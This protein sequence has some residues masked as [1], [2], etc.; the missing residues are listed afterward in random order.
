MANLSPDER[1]II[2]T[3]PLANSL[4]YLREPLRQAEQNYRP[5]SISYNGTLTD[6]DLTRQE[7]ISNLLLALMG[8]KVAFNL[9]SRTES[10]DIASELSTLFRRVRN[11]NMNYEHYRAL[12]RLVVKKAPDVNIWNAVFDLIITVSRT[13][14]PTSIPPSFN[15][16]PVTKSSSS[17][18]GSEQ[19]R[20][21]IESAM[22]YEIKGC[23]YRNV[24]GFFEKYFEGRPWSR[25]SKGIY[26]AVKKQYRGGRW[27][28]FPDPPDEDAVWKWLSRFQDKH[29]SDSRGILYT[30][31]STSDLTGGEAQRQLDVFIKRRGMETG[32]KHDWKDV[33]VIGELKRSEWNLKK[34]LLQLAR[35]MRDAFT[36]QPTR[37]FIHGFFLHGTIMELWV[38]D[39]SGPYSSGEFDIHEE[40]EKFIRAI[41]GY[42][43][44][45]DEELGL[46][47]FTEQDDRGRLIT[48]SKD[49]TGKENRMQLYEAPFVKQRAVVCRG[50]TCFR[51]SD[52]ANVVKFSWT[53]DK[54]PPEA[55]HL[56]LAREKGVEGIAKLI[57]YQRVTS[58]NELRCGLTFPSPHR[59][60]DVTASA[61]TSFSQ[62]QLGQS[63]GP[64]QNPSISK[65][66]SKRKRP[67]D[68]RGSQKRSR[69]D[70]QKSKLSQQYEAAQKPGEPAVSLY[71]SDNG[72]YSNR[73][74]G[75]LA[76][77]PAGRALSEF[78]QRPQSTNS[79]PSLIRELLT[80]L[81]DAIKAHRSLLLKANILH[82]DISENNIIITNKDETGFSGMLIDLDLAKVLGNG[83]SGA[84]H[85]T[86]TMEFM[87]IEVLLGIDHTYRHDL[88]SF[89]Y[90]LIWLCARR[91]WDL[92]GNPKG[93]PKESV[94]TK[95]YSGS[96]KDMARSKLGDMHVDGFEDIL[97]EF[98]TVFDYVKPLCRKIRGILFPLQ[99]DGT[100]FKGTRPDLPERLYD[101]IIEAFDSVI[102]DIPS[103]QES[104]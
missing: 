96:L 81:R 27:T 65:T 68:E 100:L 63:F 73:I 66:S 104:E 7:A 78:T 16:T 3:H 64:I 35:Y 77:A 1:V 69:S 29:L 13:T 49:A 40:P 74:F 12:S 94:L 42:V 97:D 84:R 24:G 90:V 60:R 33:R 20:K 26:N 23:T 98:P 71:E 4:E 56:R 99:K 88:E 19:T 17:F 50:T 9:R 86:G 46:D 67:G 38:F 93:R 58:I 62:T 15:G 31:E 87:A 80:T 70:S 79:V 30:T 54:R 61:S 83:R 91:G 44:M 89:F 45:D 28:D 53:S 72:N 34:I 48:I 75:C 22:F 92:C 55:D 10:G 41:A 25:K 36:A 21:I 95:W 6:Q 57:G 37:R 76:I 5:G 52:Q 103:R 101:P 59:F 32:G 11:A 43:M 47:T 82:R 85:Q 39:R 8:H 14:P 51:S 102:T 18:Q 2:A